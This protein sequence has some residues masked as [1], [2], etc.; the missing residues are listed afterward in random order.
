MPRGSCHRLFGRGLPGSLLA[1]AAGALL[2]LSFPRAG[3]PALAWVA[4]TPLLVAVARV[5][6]A[7][8]AFRLGLLAGIVHFG[9]VLYWIP[10]VVAEYGGLPGAASWLVHVLLV[11]YLSLFPALFAAGTAL[12]CRR[13]GAAGLACAPALWVTTE[14]GR[15][16][17]FT[18]FPW[19]LLGYSQTGVLPVAQLASLAGVFGLSALVAAVNA[20]LAFAAL[21]RGVRG[22][23][24]IAAMTAVLLA[25]V[26]FGAW[27]LAAG[28][29][30]ERGR[31]LRVAAVQG[32]VAQRDK[33][34]PA[35]RDRILDTYLDLTRQAAGAGA[36]LVVWP[37]AST[38]FAFESDPARAASIRAVARDTGAHLLLGTTELARGGG[39]RLFNAAVLVDPAGRTA[40]SYRKHHLVPFGEY[41]PLR[42]LLFFVSPLVETAGDF[43]AGPGPRTLVMDGEPL[44]AAICY[45][46][47]YPELVRG[48]VTRG[49]RLLTTVT[50]DAWYGR[51]AAPYQ[52]FQQAAMRAIEQGRFLVRAANTGISGVVDPYGR[53][54]VRTPLFARRVVTAEVRLLDERTLYSRTGDVLAYACA[55]WSALA[56]WAGARRAGGA[57]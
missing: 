33:W 53:I 10:R 8:E 50:N 41:V 31:P 36:R 2:A 39:R 9:G 19:E 12:V 54:V 15:M 34:N 45:E 25:A 55:A 26:G 52:H 5:R 3:H 4:L 29:L 7:P 35:L 56:L 32:N 24:A 18:G 16:H 27:R 30:L 22:V 40:G 23:R 28:A 1:A 51:S 49:S 43:S 48:F 38:P 47:I 14:L 21:A 20:T 11:A 42:R 57:V 46:I 6:S 17:L 13:F 44:G 37:E